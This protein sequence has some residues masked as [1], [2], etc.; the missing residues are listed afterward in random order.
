MVINE[1][2]TQPIQTLGA[3]E[4]SSS[5]RMGNHDDE[6]LSLRIS[7]FSQTQCLM[8][9]FYMGILVSSKKTDRNSVEEREDFFS[10][11][12]EDNGKLHQFLGRSQL[13]C[14]NR[15]GAILLL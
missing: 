3:T 15:A 2:I 7:L 10:P 13:T 1:S 9:K 6:H 8:R 11:C 4:N 12:F 14:A 5:P